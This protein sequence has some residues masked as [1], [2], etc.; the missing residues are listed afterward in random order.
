VTAADRQTSATVPGG[1]GREPAADVWVLT[2]VRAV[3]SAPFE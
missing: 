1:I 2:T 3:G